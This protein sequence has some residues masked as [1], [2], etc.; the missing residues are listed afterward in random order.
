MYLE[1][2]YKLVLVG[3]LVATIVVALILLVPFMVASS[4]SNEVVESIESMHPLNGGMHLGWLEGNKNYS[5]T[6]DFI[7]NTYNVSV[8]VFFFS[9]VA[10]GNE[11]D[12]SYTKLNVFYTQTKSSV[13]NGTKLYPEESLPVDYKLIVKP[14]NIPEEDG[15]FYIRVRC[16][17]EGEDY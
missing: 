11:T 1:N 12:S 9:Y 17:R 15:D 13:T 3:L 5:Y 7:R 6:S 10:V 4:P 8:K 14:H 2:L 16:L